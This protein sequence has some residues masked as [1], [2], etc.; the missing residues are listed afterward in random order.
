MEQH[1]STWAAAV[2]NTIASCLEQIGTRRS[3]VRDLVGSGL[4]TDHTVVIGQVVAF[5][6][7][8][9]LALVH[10]PG[11]SARIAPCPR[12]PCPSC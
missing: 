4:A 8:A 3:E 6:P 1:P 2:D 10:A 9:D 12:R 7:G 11:A 5:D